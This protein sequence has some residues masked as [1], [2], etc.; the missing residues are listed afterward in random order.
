MKKGE[1]RKFV[2]LYNEDMIQRGEKDARR[3]GQAFLSSILFMGGIMMVIAAIVVY[4]AIAFVNSG[5]GSQS[6]EIAEAAA[7][8]G[9]NDA[10]MRIARNSPFPSSTYSVAVQNNTAMVT[11]APYPVY[12]LVAGTV[13]VL[14]RATVGGRVRKINL[15]ISVSSST[16]QSTM[17][18]WRDVQ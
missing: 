6:S 7:T 12:P 5:Y 15:V 3:S 14:S 4:L 13:T 17:V 8:A 11:I 1:R 2:L 10:F 9:A 16:G 18:S